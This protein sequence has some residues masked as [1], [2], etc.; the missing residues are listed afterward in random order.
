MLVPLLYDQMK[1]QK[2]KKRSSKFVL[3][4]EIVLVSSYGSFFSCKFF[5]FILRKEAR[6]GNLEFLMWMSDEENM[7]WQEGKIKR[8]KH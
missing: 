3:M 4:D 5:F 1:N 6:T 8:K 2:N 7:K